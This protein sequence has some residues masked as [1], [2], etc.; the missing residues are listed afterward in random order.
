MPVGSSSTG[1]ISKKYLSADADYMDQ[2]ALLKKAR[3][4]YIAQQNQAKTGYETKYAMDLN[5]YNQNRKATVSDEENDYAS[6]GMMQSGLYAD[7]M[8]KTADDWDQRK[9]ALELA[10]AQYIGGLNSDL[11]NFSEQQNIT[12][13]QAQQNAA[14]RRAAR[15]GIT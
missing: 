13:I 9:G 6:R 8:H 11:V 5:S 12:D 4:D 7:K 2:K 10:R 3:D 1:A 14:A 15:L